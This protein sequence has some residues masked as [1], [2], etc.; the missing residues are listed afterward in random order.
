MGLRDEVHWTPRCQGV[1]LGHTIPSL[2]KK[3]SHSPLL[4]V[5]LLL[6]GLAKDLAVWPPCYEK[7]SIWV[8]G[9]GTAGG[10][11]RI[12]RAD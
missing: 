6:L 2:G 5:G 3:C 1:C 10:G 8:G 12:I 7:V 4:L 11:A 9:A